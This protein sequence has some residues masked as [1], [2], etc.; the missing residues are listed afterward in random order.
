MSRLTNKVFS[1]TIAGW[2]V[3]ASF[4]VAPLA[5]QAATN[6]FTFN[7][8]TISSGAGPSNPANGATS[9]SGTNLN[10]GDV[11]VFDGVVIN[12]PGST[13]DAWGAINLDAGGY[14]GLTGA[15]LGVL[16]ESGTASGNGWQLF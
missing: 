12:V 3:S 6:T 14:L 13:S 11:V 5:V 10:A 1:K 8:T 4:V 15:A 2:M 9:I 16:A 7:N